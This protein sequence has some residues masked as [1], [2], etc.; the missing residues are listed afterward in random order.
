MARALFEI[1]P[2]LQLCLDSIDESGEI[3]PAMDAFFDSILE[4]EAQK[5]DSYAWAIAICNA[6][7][8]AFD[9]EAAFFKRKAD[10]RKKKAEAL[11][12]RMLEHL[13]ATGRTEVRSATGKKIKVQ[14]NGG[15]QPLT[16]R[17]DKVLPDEYTKVFVVVDHDK[18]RNAI[19]A[20]QELEFAKLEE[21][22]K[23]V[24]IY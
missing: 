24:R 5:L 19:A 3:D 18:I 22:G 9:E 1:T 23:H 6:E 15:I 20:G 17:D 13:L 8:K 2:D 4:E 14:S 21:R 12:K 7:N 16:I 10:A 11:K